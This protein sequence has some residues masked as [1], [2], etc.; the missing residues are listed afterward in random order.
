VGALA[1]F[2]SVEYSIGNGSFA[3]SGGYTRI[4]GELTAYGWRS[5]VQSALLIGALGT[6]VAAAIWRVAYR[7]SYDERS[8]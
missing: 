6:I 7:R 4:D 8:A 1:L 2:L 5:I 3:D